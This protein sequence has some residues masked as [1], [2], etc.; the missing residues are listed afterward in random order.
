MGDARSTLAPEPG[1][2]PRVSAMPPEPHPPTFIEGRVV[3]KK[4]NALQITFHD[5]PGDPMAVGVQGT[6]DGR[7]KKLGMLLGFKN[8]GAGN[9]QLTF[10]DG[11]VI[12]VGSKDGA[13]SAFARG[14]G[15]NFAIVTRGATSV[16]VLT[17][18]TSLFEFVGDPTEAKTADLFRL[19]V[20]TGSGEQLGRLDVIRRVDGWSMSRALDA[21]WQTYFWWDRAGQS[22]PVPILGTRLSLARAVEGVERDVLLAACVDMAIGLRPYAAAMQ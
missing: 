6:N 14:D 2:A 13:P 16:A 12:S 22:L 21:A 8:G 20:S 15:T 5:G 7:A 19:L 3:H 11:S 9:H 17:D 18:G 1:Q 4:S 10:T